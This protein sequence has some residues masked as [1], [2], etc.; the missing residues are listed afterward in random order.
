MDNHH[1]HLDLA[2]SNHGGALL[3]MRFEALPNTGD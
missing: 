1:G 3:R 2:T